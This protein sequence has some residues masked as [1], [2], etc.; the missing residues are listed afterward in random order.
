MSKDKKKSVKELNAE[1][2]LLAERVKKLEEKDASEDPG[3]VQEKLNGIEEILK[4]YDKKIGDLDRELLQARHDNNIEKGK[5]SKRIDGDVCDK[6]SK[7]K[8]NLNEHTKPM[9]PKTY[10]CEICDET[11][12]E[13][14]KME[15]HLEHHG[16]ERPFKCSIC[17]KGFYMK[18]RMEKHT[19]DH[20]VDIK[21]CH[22][23]NSDKPCPYD[24]VGCRFKH[25]T[26]PE[27]RFNLKC[28]FKLCQF[29]HTT[30]KGEE[31]VHRGHLLPAIIS[32]DRT[33]AHREFTKPLEDAAAVE[34]K[35]DCNGYD[36]NECNQ[37]CGAPEDNEESS[38]EESHEDICDWEVKE[39]KRI[40]ASR[41]SDADTSFNG[42][43]KKK[44]R[45]DDSEDSDSSDDEETD[46]YVLG[47]SG[48]LQKYS[49]AY[50]RGGGDG[51]RC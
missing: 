45:R 32:T 29:T 41:N 14:W 5:D 11:F 18:W 25:E 51:S 15:E 3:K 23:F 30:K 4:S 39:M 16:N 36:C 35:E 33:I 44:M 28:T 6:T 1:L 2:E 20:R 43:L 19:S 47:F 50:A 7:V 22:Y 27:C 34:M 38:D 10:K 12:T 21:F 24:K 8:P 31:A 48:L 13:S 37:C 40:L 17:E 42:Q 26:A 46:P 49:S 9:H